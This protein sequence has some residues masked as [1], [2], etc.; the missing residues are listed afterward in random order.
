[1]TPDDSQ[2]DILMR[3]Y[4]G[5]AVE[6]RP[7]L[8]HLDPDEMN[9]FAEG[10]LPAATRTRYVSHLA[11]CEDC[12]R[13]TSQLTM[14]AGKTAEISLP[15]SETVTAKSWWAKLTDLSA[16]P[17]LRYA[18][19][20]LVIL[21]VVGIAFVV[22]R[23]PAN[24]DASLIAL[25]QPTQQ[26]RSAGNPS[27]VT[28]PQ[29]E[30]NKAESP[31]SGSVAQAT[32]MLNMADK[33]TTAGAVSPPP[34]AAK[35]APVTESETRSTLA[36]QPVAPVVAQ[37]APAYSPQPPADYRLDSRGREQQSIATGSPGGPR[38]NESYEK[39]KSDANSVD[40]AKGRDEDR[41][42]AADQV[43]VAGNKP[44]EAVASPSSVAG[45]LAVRR[46]AKDLKSEPRKEAANARAQTEEEDLKK[47]QSNESEIRS[48]GG[49]RFER[50]G[51]V[52]IDSKFKTSMAVKTIARGS[53]DFQK[54][55]AGLRAIAQQLSGD[56]I[57]VWKGK[58]YRIR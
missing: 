45:T 38:R 9:A 41:T 39:N 19:S 37:K 48:V 1:M 5:R 35:T 52:W 46:Q 12:R 20:A 53:D 4:A 3:R 40:F 42:R 51:G 6:P 22:W 7:G 10:I 24:R 15:A 47:K 58:G 50:Q 29:V 34:P 31:N 27:V 13:L 17:A 57:V 49:R 43:I 14:A 36:D 56:I 33:Q 2:M 25:N 44:A 11:D 26:E 55:D 28:E 23:R 18:A 21:I 16:L 30:R 8:E 32:P 54:L